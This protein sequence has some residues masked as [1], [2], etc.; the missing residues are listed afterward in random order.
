MK[1]NIKKSLKFITLLVTSIVIATVSAQ[2]YTYMFMEG[3]ISIGT[4]KIVWI[5]EGQEISGDTVTMSF[6]VEPEVVKSV[7]GS[8]YLKNK[9]TADHNLTITVTDAVTGSNFKVCKIYIYD[10]FTQSGQWT[11]V[12]VLDVETLNDEYSTYTDNK[13]LVDGGYYRFDFEIE[14]ESTASSDSF[15]ITVRYE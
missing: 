5:K 13:P 11:F 9:D 8:L 4:Q 3:S 15:K 14:A 1:I 6:T 10:N 7:N 2:T 12:D